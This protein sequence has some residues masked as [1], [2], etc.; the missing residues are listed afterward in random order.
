VATALLALAA[1]TVVASA[2]DPHICEVALGHGFAPDRSR[3][4]GLAY[5]ARSTRR[6]I[7]R[8]RFTGHLLGERGDQPMAGRRSASRGLAWGAVALAFESPVPVVVAG[9]LADPG[10]ELLEGVEALDPQ[11]SLRVWMNFSTTPLVSGS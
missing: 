6:R 9:E 5:A 11:G 3:E 8:P 2:I 7:R 10:A 4:Q 1:R